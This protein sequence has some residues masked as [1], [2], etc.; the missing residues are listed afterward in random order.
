MVLKPGFQ[1]QLSA[2]IKAEVERQMSKIM[3][4]IKGWS[5][6]I[7]KLDE[8]AVKA[9][10]ER[11]VA[12]KFASMANKRVQRLEKNNYTHTNAYRNYLRDGG[13]KF[14]IRGKT[15]EEVQAE[16]RRMIRF[17]D[18][19]DSTVKQARQIMKNDAAYF[20]IRYKNMKDLQARHKAFFTIFQSAMK[21][22][23]ESQNAAAAFGYNKVGDE[24]IRYAEGKK[25]DLDGGEDEVKQALEH[26][27]KALGYM[28]QPI[29]T[30]K[31]VIRLRDSSN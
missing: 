2:Q 11:K 29:S 12:S 10:A 23:E 22:Y 13:Q 16:M 19:A 4:E 25:W 28:E 8:N 18:A 15:Q 31:G 7:G 6:A 5:K 14:S 30:P 26:I 21:F 17:L 20:G 27:N 1:R 24:I 9:S 3:P